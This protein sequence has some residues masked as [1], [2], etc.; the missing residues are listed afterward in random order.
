MPD[1]RELAIVFWLLV[2]LAWILTRQTM[3]TSL[4]GVVRAAR[5]P[6]ISVPLLLMSVYAVS[7]IIALR[8]VRVWTSD[9]ITESVFWFA[10]TA[11]ALFMAFDRASGDPRFFRRTAVRTLSVSVFVAFLVNLYAMSFVL[12]L[13]LVPVLVLLGMVVALVQARDEFAAVKGFFQAT[14]VAAGLALLTYGLVR[15]VSDPSAV[16]TISNARR[17]G[18]P[19]LLTIALLP[20][21]YAL[22]VY[23]SY[24]ALLSR[25]R[26]QL[27]DEPHVYRYARRRLLLA[28]GLRLRS[29]VRASRAPWTLMLS[30]PSSCTEL[31]R[32]IA[33][34][35]SRRLNVLA[36]S[37]ADEKRI[38]QLA[39]ERPDGW[40]YLVFAA[41]LD[42][43]STALAHGLQSP[44]TSGRS[45]E[46]PRNRDR[47]LRIL[48][49]DSRTAAAIVEDLVSIFD[50]VRVLE[51]FG[52][53]G[54]PGDARR[55]VALAE[56]FITNYDQMLQWSER[57][58]ATRTSDE[59]VDLVQTHAE[60]MDL[61]N[62]QVDEYIDRWTALAD[63]LP[64]LLVQAERSPEP[65]KLDLSL[66]LT[67]DDDVLA[68]YKA[69]L[70]R[71]GQAA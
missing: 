24:D 4:M 43:A 61:P 11:L 28:V 27:R 52:A 50:E 56:T 29:V 30:S 49:E 26:Y 45:Y 34:L 39:D 53:P 31:D 20:F 5:T 63:E 64:A 65:V 47:V 48:S 6:K 37:T 8:W 14:A 60:L 19:A 12:E 38:A 51:A 69:E 44:D 70:A 54:E 9:L 18:M 46:T 2:A 16:A 21:V 42:A 17:L 41:R 62:Q 22:T 71:I 55:I 23:G 7:T 58:R 25:L 15:A 67:V 1:N 57:A 66:T 10:G 68:R 59:M 40:E 13:A 3:R 35:R 36:M 32:V 33:H